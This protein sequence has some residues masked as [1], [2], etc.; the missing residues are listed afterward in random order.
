MTAGLVAHSSTPL[1][2]LLKPFI[3]DS[4][5]QTVSCF[6]Y[7]HIQRSFEIHTIFFLY[8]NAYAIQQPFGFIFSFGRGPP[9]RNP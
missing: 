7:T 2:Q 1:M 5:E 9:A 6:H 8:K 4:E 3:Y